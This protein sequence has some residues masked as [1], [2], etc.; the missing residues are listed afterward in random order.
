MLKKATLISTLLLVSAFHAKAQSIT[1]VTGQ[2]SDAAGNAYQNCH[3]NVSLDRS[4]AADG[5]LPPG[6]QEIYSGAS[7]DSN[8]NLAIDLPDNTSFSP[9]GTKWRFSVCSSDGAH[10]NATS[11]TIS[12]ASQNITS[13]LQAVLPSIATNLGTFSASSLNVSGTS[14]LNNLSV[15]GSVQSA[16]NLGSNALSAGAVTASSVNNVIKVDQQAGADLAAKV[17]ACI[18]ALPA[19]G[20]VCDARGAQGAQSW[21][22]LVSFSKPV[23]LLLPAGTITVTQGN[24]F[25][26]ASDSVNLIGQGQ[27]STLIDYSGTSG[28]VISNPTTTT[29]RNYFRAADFALVSTGGAGVTST[30]INFSG[31]SNSR[32]EG[33]L[34]QDFGTQWLGDSPAGVSTVYNALIHNRFQCSSASSGFNGVEIKGNTNALKFVGGNRFS[35]CNHQVETDQDGANTTPNEVDLGNSTFELS[36][37]SAVHV[38]HGQLIATAPRF[39]NAN[40]PWQCEANFDAQFFATK[41]TFGVNTNLPVDLSGYCAVDA[42]GSTGSAN[43]HSPGGITDNT[44]T[45][46]VRNPGL[47]AWSATTTAYEWHQVAVPNFNAAAGVAF[48]QDTTAA[49]VHSGT[50][51]AKVTATSGRGMV[52]ATPIPIQGTNTAA[53]TLPR[54]YTFGFW[55]LP[56]ATNGGFVPCFKI[57]DSTSTEITTG[58]LVSAQILD[59]AGVSDRTQASFTYNAGDGCWL[60]GAN[61]TGSLSWH[62]S[63]WT[64]KLPS[65]AQTIQPG[66]VVFNPNVNNVW[67]DDFCFG[68]GECTRRA[69]PHAYPNDGTETMLTSSQDYIEQAAPS[70][71][72]GADRCYGDSTAHALECSYNNGTFLKAPQIITAIQ[73]TTAATTDNVTVTGMVSTGH[74]YLTPTNSAAAAGI[75]SVFISAKTTNQITVTHTAT[76]GW[77]FDVV[78]SP[79]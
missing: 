57:F 3:F 44:H 12:G 37:S 61:I 39:E 53:E 8:G 79:Q 1:H 22:S 33:V 68:E 21:G 40:T 2:A 65:N 14:T 5:L 50:S 56:A 59:A 34:I 36:D 9:T 16:L 54:T 77:T 35:R 69:T 48:N 72:A 29:A 6:F 18:T 71:I 66:V 52:V 32:M 13:N 78:C 63:A 28:T 58:T 47:E 62:F 4:T 11:I 60:I 27:N 24:G 23:A 19:T 73:T 49:N 51:S 26:I 41:P 76:A 7:C 42:Q 67:F 31:L 15:T 55:W 43:S 46:L 30:G 45:Q 75:A 25:S 64:L 20:G 10:C 70:A 38:I 74:C 17:A